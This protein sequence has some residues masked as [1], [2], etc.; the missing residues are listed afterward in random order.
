MSKCSL[1]W[2]T[3]VT[4]LNTGAR[5]IIWC[6]R[7]VRCG[8]TPRPGLPPTGRTPRRALRRPHRSGGKSPHQTFYWSPSIESVECTN[9]RPGRPKLDHAGRIL[10][11]RMAGFYGASHFAR[12]NLNLW[13]EIG[14]AL[15]STAPA[16]TPELMCLTILSASTISRADTQRSATLALRNFERRSLLA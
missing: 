3:C 12:Y 13:L 9:C 4:S 5:I 6:V 10:Y 2:L 14:G 15:H 11:F 7:I 16:I 8:I 1:R